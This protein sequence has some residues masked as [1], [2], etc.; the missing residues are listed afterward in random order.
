MNEVLVIGE[1]EGLKNTINQDALQL[2]KNNLVFKELHTTPVN[3][4]CH[5]AGF[6][7]MISWLYML[8]YESGR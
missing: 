4:T 5:E 8:Y 6:L 3:F 7:R 1:L 2:G